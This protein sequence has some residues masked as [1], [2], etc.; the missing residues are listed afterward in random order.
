MLL[1]SA[2]SLGFLKHMVMLLGI[3]VWEVDFDKTQMLPQTL[4]C[5]CV[6]LGHKVAAGR[7]K[8]S[9]HLYTMLNVVPKLD[10]NMSL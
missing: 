9:T 7:K 3:L 8:I 4:F 5:S 2:V 1:L 6:A 10:M